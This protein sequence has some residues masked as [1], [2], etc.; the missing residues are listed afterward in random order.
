MLNI[1][2]LHGFAQYIKANVIVASYVAMLYQFKE[3]VRIASTDVDVIM[4]TW[5]TKTQ[6]HTWSKMNIHTQKGTCI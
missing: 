1:K 3:V 5:H 4:Y 2:I 6:L